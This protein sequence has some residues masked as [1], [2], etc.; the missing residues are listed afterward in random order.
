MDMFRKIRRERPKSRTH[1]IGSNSLSLSYS[2]SLRCFNLNWNW[3]FESSVKFAS[4]ETNSI[5]ASIFIDFTRDQNSKISI[6]MIWWKEKHY[7]SSHLISNMIAA[8][9]KQF[10]TNNCNN[11]NSTQLNSRLYIKTTTKNNVFTCYFSGLIQKY[12]YFVKKTRLF[13]PIDFVL[14]P[15]KVAIQQKS[16]ATKMNWIHIHISKL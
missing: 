10:R 12:V 16:T 14:Y 4:K 8:T 1:R 13:P 15:L 7:F 2:R 6:M 9:R 3:F 5:F 11:T